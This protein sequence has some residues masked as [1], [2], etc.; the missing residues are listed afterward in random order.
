ME[1]KTSLFRSRT[2]IKLILS[3][4]TSKICTISAYEKNKTE[5]KGLYYLI[6]EVSKR[7][8]NISEKIKLDKLKDYSDI[9]K[10]EEECLACQA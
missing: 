5:C 9:K 10:D 7:T 3:S 2:I 4:D 8:E 6:T 1:S